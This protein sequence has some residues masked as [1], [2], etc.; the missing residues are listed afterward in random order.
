[1]SKLFSIEFYK[2]FYDKVLTY[3][4]TKNE[5]NF[6]IKVLNLN[7]KNKILDLACW[8]WRHTEFLLNQWFNVYWIDFSESF[9]S[10]IKEISQYKKKYF[11]WDI[12]IKNV[13]WKK[14]DKIYSLH[15]SFWYFS[16][17]DNEKIIENISSLLN[18]NW[19]FLIDLNNPYDTLLFEKW[20]S[21]L[22]KW[23]D[24]IKDIKSIKNKRLIFKRIIKKWDDIFN[25]KYS[26]RIYTKDE[27]EEIWKKYNLLLI[28]TFWDFNFNK[29][30]K[31]SKRMIL[32]FK[33]Q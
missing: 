1:M 21:I 26:L 4:R 22:Q 24:Y 6:L 14:F 32:L 28:K 5:V 23:D 18:I 10:H 7:K 29:F 17:N 13:L 31:D 8:F 27:L 9:I 25:E 20:E 3:Q 15:T 11:L 2:Y 16:E 19:L 12:R 33:K 30:N